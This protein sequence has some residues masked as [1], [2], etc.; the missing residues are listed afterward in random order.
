MRYYKAILNTSSEKILENATIKLRDY[1]YY[2][3]N[4]INAVNG[5]IY[6]CLKSGIYFLIYREEENGIYAGIAFDEKKY[7]FETAYEE[8]KELFQSAFGSGCF[9]QEPTECTMFE[10]NDILVESR[11]RDMMN[12]SSVSSWAEMTNVYSYYLTNQENTRYF[13]SYDEKIVSDRDRKIGA[14]YDKRQKD[15]ASL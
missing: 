11:R 9:K 1:G 7:I 15:H 4:V 3:N 5:Y 8:V 14:I 12:Y 13:F 6:Q 2:N 10:Y